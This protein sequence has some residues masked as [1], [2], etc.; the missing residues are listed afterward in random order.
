MQQ[1]IIRE[2]YDIIHTFETTLY[3]L[4]W[5]Q[6]ENRGIFCYDAEIEVFDSTLRRLKECCINNIGC[7]ED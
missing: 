1:E 7:P 2:F 4:K 5:Q 3:A 6:H